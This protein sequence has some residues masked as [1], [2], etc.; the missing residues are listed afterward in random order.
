MYTI[1]AEPSFE[2]HAILA[3]PLIRHRQLKE[4]KAW[5]N[6][7]ALNVQRYGYPRNRELACY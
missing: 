4:I 7:T 5:I 6:G 2:E 3:F 1:G